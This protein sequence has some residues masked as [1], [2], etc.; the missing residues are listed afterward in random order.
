M[1]EFSLNN[2]EGLW[3]KTIEIIERYLTT[4][5]SQPV[6]PPSSADQISAALAEYTFATPHDPKEIVASVG[7]LLTKHLL[8]TSHPAYFGVFNPASATMGIAADAIVAAFNPQL[9]SSPSGNIAIA[10]EDHLLRFFGEKFGFARKDIR[11]NFTSG[12]TAANHTALLC[13]LTQKVPR[14]GSDGLGPNRPA[15]YTSVE[16]HHSI[17][18]SA[19]LCG[20]GTSSVR[21][22]PVRKNLEL[23]AKA[24][25]NQIA[26]DRQEGYLPLFLVATLGTTSAGTFDHLSELVAIARNEDL[27]LHADAAWG[28]AAIL[29]EE[30]RVLFQGSEQVDSITLDAHKWLSV[31][32]GAGLFITRHPEILEG[33]FRVDQSPY[34]PG[35]TYQASST[36]PYKQSLEWSKRFIGLKLFMTLA[37]H[38]EEGYRQTLRHQI[39]MGDRLRQKLTAS[40][41]TIVNETPL[42]VICF[43]DETLPHLDTVDFARRVAETG[44]TW[45]TPTELRFNGQKVLRAGISN[46][47]TQESDLDILVDTLNTVRA[48]L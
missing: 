36:E 2:R 11:G 5:S 18:R 14:F 27:W 10:I 30:Y 37:T 40:R 29:L 6:S 43:V 44:R 20:L 35:Q 4:V 45:I 21:T 38:G 16:T 25:V 28:G 9:A 23:N 12:G 47:L 24:L 39:R 8:H 3:K 13:A 15:I 31:P 48:S 22:L 46:F 34:M 19:R 42:P 26:R 1:L 33:T 32:M 17:L 41:W 7:E